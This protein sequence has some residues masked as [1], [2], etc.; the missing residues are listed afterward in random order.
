M[1]AAWGRVMRTGVNVSCGLP[2]FMAEQIVEAGGYSASFAPA[3]GWAVHL[4]VSLSYALLFGVIVLVLAASRFPAQV[5]MSFAVA[6]ALGLVT[7]V[8]APPAISVTIGVASGQ[9]WPQ[10]LFPLNTELG[11]PFWNHVGFFLLNWLVQGLG[12]HLLQ[13]G[14]TR[15]AAVGL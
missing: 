13:V 4:G 8:V 2:A 5:A 15:N 3:I 12:P 14:A 10:E 6:V 11:L 7:A 1:P 9:G